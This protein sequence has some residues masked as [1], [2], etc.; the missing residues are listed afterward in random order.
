MTTEDR[1]TTAMV[2]CGITTTIG[3]GGTTSIGIALII[4][5]LGDGGAMVTDG[6]II[7]D[8]IIRHTVIR[9]IITTDTITI[10]TIMV[11]DVAM[12]IAEVEG[13]TTTGTAQQIQTLEVPH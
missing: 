12:P 5:T 7:T 3:T 10:T 4:T 9:H 11:V 8:T 2:L 13:D 6:T 1:D